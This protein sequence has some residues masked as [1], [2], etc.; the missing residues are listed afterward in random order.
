MVKSEMN[1]KQINDLY[2]YDF[3]SGYSKSKTGAWFELLEDYIYFID[4]LGEDSPVFP[5]GLKIQF[6]CL[7]LNGWEFKL[8]QPVEPFGNIAVF[9]RSRL[10]KL[11]VKEILVG[12]KV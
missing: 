5:K 10:L 8:D 6:R 1:H 3:M 4:F 12:D 9:G 2:V 11:K 7:T